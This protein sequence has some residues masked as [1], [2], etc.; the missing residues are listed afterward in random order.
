MKAITK[1][2]E[3]TAKELKANDLDYKG[4]R[5][6]FDKSES[7]YFTGSHFNSAITYYRT[8]GELKSVL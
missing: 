3:I 5:L 7:L 1:K 4:Q 2:S 6:G 8:I